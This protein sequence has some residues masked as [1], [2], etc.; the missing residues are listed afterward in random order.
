MD[1]CEHRA[2]RAGA[3]RGCCPRRFP[4]AVIDSATEQAT[5]PILIDI[6][7]DDITGWDIVA[8]LGPFAILITGLIAEGTSYGATVCPAAAGR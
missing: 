5:E 8:N 3:R 4:N 2:G 1:P 6:V 7:S